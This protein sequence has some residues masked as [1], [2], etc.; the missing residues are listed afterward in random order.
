MNVTIKSAYSDIS[1][2]GRDNIPS[3]GAVIFAPNHTNALMDA[4]SVLIVSQQPTVFVARADMFKNRILA[5]IMNF[6]KIMPIMR[7]RDG[8]ENMKKNDEIIAAAADVLVH[9][10]PFCIFCEGTH[11]MK[12]SLLPIVKGIFRI[13]VKAESELKDKMPLYIVPVGIEYGSYVKYS[14]SL[15]LNIGAPINVTDFINNHGEDAYPKLLVEL[16]DLLF[17]KISELIHYV[18]DD[19]NYDV[20][21]DLSY[22][23][24]SSYLNALKLNNTPYNEMMA[25]RKFIDDFHY[26][27]SHNVPKAEKLLSLGREFSTL[28]RKLKIAD[29]TLITPT[30]TL[31][32][33]AY[34]FELI[35]T[36][37]YFI[38]SLIVSSPV[39]A[40]SQ[41]LIFKSDDKAFNNTFRYA[42]SIV[43]MPVILI[44][45]SV[46]LFSTVKWFFAVLL[47]ILSIPSF[48]FVHRYI[49]CFRIF[50]SDIKFRNNKKLNNLTKQINDCL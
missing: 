12:H 25:N 18:D 49:R 1:I 37:P 35:F 23:R 11:R 43:L 41:F 32:S 28:R 44:I 38:Y 19:E 21:L 46:I 20:L 33:I 6:F 13:A 8:R 24:N 29:E 16:K 5:K 7:I 15:C 31:I 14:S 36:L 47:L 2:V 27:Q 39:I 45:L 26:I 34:L 48:S 3:D 42:L 50:I 22:L 40:L 30:S 4:L 9:K 17:H 10:V